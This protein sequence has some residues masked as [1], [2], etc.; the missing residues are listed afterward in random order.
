MKFKKSEVSVEFLKGREINEKIFAGIATPVLVLGNGLN[1][2]AGVFSKGWPGLLEKIGSNLF[3][4]A[5]LDY[6]DDF[7]RLMDA[8]MPLTEVYDWL[9]IKHEEKTEK[10]SDKKTI[11]PLISKLVYDES[12]KIS[13]EGEDKIRSVV[14]YCKSK[15]MPIL[16]TNYDQLLLPANEIYGKG[17]CKKISGEEVSFQKPRWIGGLGHSKSY[18]INAYYKDIE[19]EN[20]NKLEEEFAIWHIN[21]IACFPES[22]RLNSRDYCYYAHRLNGKINEKNILP[23]KQEDLNRDC[24]SFVDILFRGNLI[25]AGM[26]L[27]PQETIMRWLLC[28]RKR[29]YLHNKLEMPKSV[30]LRYHRTKRD[31]IN[32][33]NEM[34]LNALGIET[35]D[36][37][38]GVSLDDVF[39]DH[40][41]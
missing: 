6:V 31:Q 25:F 41:K 18:P 15:D 17:C 26:S 33:E 24:L 2:S 4:D 7:Y 32:Y 3:G 21:G 20:L 22:I 13:K 37:H 9:L 1:I 23:K 10:F 5:F 39:K 36:M 29:F 16:T 35:V 14:E 38:P 34:Y 19:F 8:K 11:N 28:E 30:F 40:N 12:K 27:E